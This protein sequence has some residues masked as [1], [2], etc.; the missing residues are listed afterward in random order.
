MAKK[1]DEGTKI[2]LTPND[3]LEHRRKVGIA[4]TE[5][6]TAK[7]NY[8]TVVEKAVKAGI[9]KKALKEVMRLRNRDPEEFAMHHR[10][11]A[12]YASWEGLAIGTKP[13]SSVRATIS[14]R[15]QGEGRVLAAPGGR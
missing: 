9:D 2:H 10:N 4:F 1:M 7:S 14:I 8:D 15:R 6:Q 13:A 5:F 11:V 3:Y 12:R